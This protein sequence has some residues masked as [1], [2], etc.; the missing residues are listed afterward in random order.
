MLHKAKIKNGGILLLK[1][2]FIYDVDDTSLYTF[3]CNV[4]EKLKLLRIKC[5]IM[6][7]T[8]GDNSF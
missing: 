6:V 1:Q 5:K 4:T 7:L 8:K 2:Y 3:K